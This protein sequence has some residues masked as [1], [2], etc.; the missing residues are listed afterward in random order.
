MKRIY[1]SEKQ[2]KYNK[3]HYYNNKR[4]RYLINVEN[5]SKI[6]QFILDY[7]KDKKCRDCN[8]NH[9]SCL[10]FHH[11]DPKEKD[12]SLYE[13]SQHQYSQAKILKE[14]E[15]CIILCA[16]CHAKLHCKEK[17]ALQK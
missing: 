6:R 9:I 1:N 17:N 16:N 3:K 7:K 8:E 4:K 2:R 5:K 14:I 12:F 10:Q 11:I 13:A 15:K